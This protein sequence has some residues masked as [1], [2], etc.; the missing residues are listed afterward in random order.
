[1]MFCTFCC[2]QELT[3]VINYIHLKSL[4][5]KSEEIPRYSFLCLPIVDDRDKVRPTVGLRWRTSQQ[6]QMFVA[7]HLTYYLQEG[8]QG[9]G[10][11]AASTESTSASFFTV[12]VKLTYFS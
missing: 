1:M 6:R 5:I 3:E 9:V 12:V 8:G 4:L 10:H 2:R 7:C 11:N